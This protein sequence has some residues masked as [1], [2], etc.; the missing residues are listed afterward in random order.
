MTSRTNKSLLKKW[1]ELI[2]IQSKDW[3]NFDPLL[4]LDQY[5]SP[6]I[7]D[8]HV[9]IIHVSEISIGNHTGRSAIND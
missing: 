1:G 9:I 3:I 8:Y 4:G 5:I 6:D 2:L 7:Q